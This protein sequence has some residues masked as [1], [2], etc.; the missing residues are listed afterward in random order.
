MACNSDIM[1]SLVAAVE[2]FMS[3]FYD[4]IRRTLGSENLSNYEKSYCV[5]PKCL[6]TQPVPDE[7]TLLLERLFVAHVEVSAHDDEN[8]ADT[9]ASPAA[10]TTEAASAASPTSSAATTPTSPTDSCMFHPDIC[11]WAREIRSCHRLFEPTWRNCAVSHWACSDAHR[12]IAKLFTKTPSFEKS[13]DDI[14]AAGML[15]MLY[16]CTDDA[17]KDIDRFSCKNVT[18]VRNFVSHPSIKVGGEL[19]CSKYYSSL[20]G[21]RKLLEELFTIVLSKASVEQINSFKTKLQSRL[22][23]VQQQ[24]TTAAGL[25]FR[26]LIPQPYGDSLFSASR[27]LNPAQLSAQISCFRVALFAHKEPPSLPEIATSPA[28][29]LTP[30]QQEQLTRHLLESGKYREVC[31]YLNENLDRSCEL[32][33]L[34]T[35]LSASDARRPA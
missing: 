11:R 15:N 23:V 5:C 33:W 34:I 32:F 6:S 31:Q 8:L 35:A 19:L 3:L 1:K 28:Q 2:Y 27:D 16:Y 14:D 24:L 4:R 29:Q 20:C 7:E 26:S 17:F 25:P 22:E 21:I 30:A 12:H 10:T 13:L 9:I 18:D